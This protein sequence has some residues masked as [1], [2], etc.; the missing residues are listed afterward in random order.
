[1][2]SQSAGDSDPAFDLRW[3]SLYDLGDH[4]ADG[5]HNG[6]CQFTLHYVGAARDNPT[7]EDLIGDLSIDPDLP[8]SRAT[9][10]R[11]YT[12]LAPWMRAH[13]LKLAMDWNGETQLADYFEANPELTVAYGFI[14]STPTGK[15]DRMEP[16]PPTQSRL[17][18]MWYQEFSDDIRDICR[19]VAFEQI[20]RAHV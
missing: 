19:S 12:P 10:H 18:E 3:D 5:S 7:V 8:D 16:Q 1:M 9:W 17:W 15:S 11:N 2:E 6:C 4:S 13:I 14:D 20:G